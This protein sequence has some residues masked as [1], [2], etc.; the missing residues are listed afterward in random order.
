MVPLPV[1]AT[2]ELALGAVKGPPVGVKVDQAA[3]EIVRV[4]K[5]A[6][7]VVRVGDPEGQEDP[8]EA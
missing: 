3:A 4:V 1:D 6:A 8:L 5:A 2:E 7:V